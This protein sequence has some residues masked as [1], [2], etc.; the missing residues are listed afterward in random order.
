MQEA[1]FSETI[2]LYNPDGAERMVTFRGENAEDWGKV[3]QEMAKYLT[4]KAKAGWRLTRPKPA[5]AKPSN[6]QSVA[7]SAPARPSPSGVHTFRATK[8]SVQFSPKGTKVGKLHGGN[9]QKYGVTVWPE[10]AQQFGFDLDKLQPGE[11]DC[12]MEVAYAVNEEGK[13]QK[14]IGLAGGQPAPQVKAARLREDVAAI[15]AG[16]QADNLQDWLAG[17][18]PAPQAKAAAASPL[19]SHEAEGFGARDEDEIPFN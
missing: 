1:G 6:G 14:V 5:D 7:S 11:Y 13:P 19:A 10:V 2:K 4:E 8:L 16:L 17:G 9:Y 15:K 18:Q 12:D 3:E